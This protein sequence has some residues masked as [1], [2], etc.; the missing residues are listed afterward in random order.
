MNVVE[1]LEGADAYTSLA[2]IASG[3]VPLDVPGAVTPDFVKDIAT[4]FLGC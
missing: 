3:N 1:M 2:E 4:P